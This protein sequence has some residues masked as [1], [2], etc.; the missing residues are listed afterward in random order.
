MIEKCQLAPGLEISR[1]LTGLW[2][3]AD[4]E[5]DGKDLDPHSSA[6]S[7]KSYVDAQFHTFDMADHYGSA[8]VIAGA[9]GQLYPGTA[10]MFTKWV[11]KP[12]RLSKVEVRSAIQKSLTRLQTDSIDLLQ[13]HAWNYADAAYLDQLFYL[14]ELKDEGLIK[15]LGLTN[16]DAPHLRVVK[17][18]GVDI[19]S[20]QICYSLLDQRASQEMTV[21][22]EELGIKILAFG[23]VAGG[24]LTEKWLGKPEPNWDQISNWSLMKY[25]RFIDVA[26]GW[27]EYQQ[28]LDVLK[29]IA[30]KNEVS[31]A[32][33]ASKYILSQPAVA[34]VI[35]GARLG[36][37]EHIADNTK[38]FE[39]SLSQEDQKSISTILSTLQPIPGRCGDEYRKPPFLTASGDL[40]HHLDSIPKPFEAVEGVNGTK[41]LSGTTWEKEFGYC[42]AIKR[43]D[44]IVVAGTTASH[45]DQL[46]GGEDP[47][48]QAH[49]VIDKIE[50]AIQS[51]GG[52]LEDVIRTRIYVQNLDDWEPIAKAHGERFRDIQPVNTLVH[53]NLVG[54]EYLVEIEAEAVISSDA[55]PMPLIG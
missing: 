7:M 49:F 51:L 39:F 21:T 32:N 24:F 5:R 40:S 13:Y 36:Q 3:I 45:G 9:Y 17:T 44:R 37:S 23:T 8:E 38:L 2:Q 16:F 11:P 12:G 47:R 14:Q 10:Q 34:G 6:L 54:E 55:N 18:S 4:L 25:K 42:R 27:E 43:G 22:C 31:V 41:V 26:G 29:R 52:H 33:V 50:G 30:L 53:A 48:A 28:V 15:H 1:V 20:N 35:I 46:I 19:V